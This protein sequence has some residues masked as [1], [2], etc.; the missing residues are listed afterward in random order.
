MWLNQV[1]GLLLKLGSPIC[2]MKVENFIIKIASRCNL[3][4]SY[5]Y[6]YN[7]GD[8][9]YKAQ[10]KHMSYEIARNVAIKIKEHCESQN[11]QSIAIVFHGGEPLLVGLERFKA[12]VEIFEKS[13]LGI[14]YMFAVQTNGVLIDGEWLDFFDSKEISIGISIDGTQGQH[15]KYRVFHNGKGSYKEVINSVRLSQEHKAFG[16][17]LYVVNS[18]YNPKEIYDNFKRE[19]V[20]AFNILLPDGHY[21]NYPDGKKDFEDISYG[22]WMIELYEVWKNDTNNRLS[23]IFFEDIIKNLLYKNEKIGN[24][25]IGN[26]DNPV[27]CIE[28]NGDIEILDSLRICEEGITRSNL[29]ALNDNIIDVFE[30]PLFELYY[31]SHQILCNTCN[32]CE[33]KRTCGGGFLPHRYSKKNKFENPTIYCKDI[34]AL[35]SYIKSDLEI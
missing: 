3:N 35:L 31:K 26:A 22:Q 8:E 18:S 10:P 1:S 32:A 2:D 25:L 6:M 14:N 9:T 21:N 11:I 13:L 28:T 30:N 29:N 27:V 33:F 12:I 5:C 16:G 23:I 17:A 20:H 7:Q 34:K 24:Q 19:N 15:D 4:C